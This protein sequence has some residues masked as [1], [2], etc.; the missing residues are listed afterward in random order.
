ML[1]RNPGRIPCDVVVEGIAHEMDTYRTNICTTMLRTNLHDVSI[2]MLLNY[3]YSPLPHSRL[4][5]QAVWR[6]SGGDY[7]H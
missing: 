1:K 6:Y 3:Q 7:N 4:I 5:L 2:K